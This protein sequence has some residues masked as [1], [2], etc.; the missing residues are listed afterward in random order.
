M[1]HI[2]VQRMHNNNSSNNNIRFKIEDRRRRVASL[3]V[4]SMI[5]T[6]IAEMLNVDQSL[7]GQRYTNAVVCRFLQRFSSE[8]YM[9]LKKILRL[10][11]QLAALQELQA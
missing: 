4:Q 8:R 7:I 11:L 5:E 2:L 9:G 3:I 6:E 10:L 1:L